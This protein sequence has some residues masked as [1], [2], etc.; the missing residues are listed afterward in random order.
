VKSAIAKVLRKL[1]GAALRGVSDNKRYPQFCSRAS[2]DES[3]FS[4][5]RSNPIYNEILEHVT[6]KQGGQ[7]LEIIATDH[8][9]FGAMD[10]FKRNDEFGGPQT[11]EYPSIGRISPSTL[12]YVKVLADLKKLFG[13][14]DDL[15][16]CEIG[17]G[18]GGQCRIIN[19]WFSSASYC[20]I[21]I[22]PALALTRRYLE[23]YAISSIL[24]Y[25]TMNELAPQD[26]DLAISNYAFTELPRAIQDEYLQKVIMRSRRGY[27]TYNEISPAEFRS[28]TADERLRLIPGAERISEE[29]LT[30]PKNCLIVWGNGMSPGERQ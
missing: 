18:Y 6:E 21:D 19:A 9:L 12:R 15:D 1:T 22:A 4:A 26:Y 7:Y 27:I 30:H 3:E 28:Y 23:N 29:P 10:R 20:L 24:S 25:R 8:V 2:R 13:S 5:F 17:I 16:I 14:L 11:S